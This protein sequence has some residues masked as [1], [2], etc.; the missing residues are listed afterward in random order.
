LEN[1]YSIVTVFT[2]QR[3]NF[4]AVQSLASQLNYQ[5]STRRYLANLATGMQNG[6]LSVLWAWLSLQAKNCLELAFGIIKL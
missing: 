3:Y 4:G 1:Y 6:A 5:D 2:N